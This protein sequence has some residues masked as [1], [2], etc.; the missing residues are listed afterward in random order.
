MKFKVIHGEKGKQQNS[1]NQN[2][3]ED[4]K[5]NT[6]KPGTSKIME[7]YYA[8]ERP[9]SQ[10]MEQAEGD[11]DIVDDALKNQGNTGDAA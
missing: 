11:E 1:Q 10:D 5:A 6:E 7:D 4:I 3:P 8:K 2:Q 9:R